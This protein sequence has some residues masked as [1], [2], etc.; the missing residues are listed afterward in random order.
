MAFPSQFED[1]LGPFGVS[2]DPEDPLDSSVDFGEIVAR[3]FPSSLEKGSSSE[4]EPLLAKTTMYTT[5][6]GL[7]T[8]DLGISG[9]EVETPLL[10]LKRGNLQKVRPNFALLLVW[11]CCSFWSLFLENS[12][13]G[14]QT[15]SK[16]LS[17]L[18]GNLL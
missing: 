17:L 5:Y 12:R 15:S 6:E 8:K 10:K 13:S 2:K 16:I 9:D 11:N 18:I 3:T 7:G 4:I 1:I 14:F